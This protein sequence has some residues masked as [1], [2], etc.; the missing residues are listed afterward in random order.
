[1]RLGGHKT[2]VFLLLRSSLDDDPADDNDGGFFDF[3]VNVDAGDD[4]DSDS[5]GVPVR[6]IFCI[7]IVLLFIGDAFM[8]LVP[9][10][11][12]SAVEGDASILLFNKGHP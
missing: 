6:S 9:V 3:L 12:V 1:M 8:V 7:A 5:V 4:V 10:M 2:T 11:I